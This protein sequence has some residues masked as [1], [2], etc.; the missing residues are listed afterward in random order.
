VNAV[1]SLIACSNFGDCRVAGEA[2]WDERTCACPNCGKML[3]S[4]H[5]VVIR[6]PA[7]SIPE[8]S[9][10]S[11]SIDVEIAK[12]CATFEKLCVEVDGQQRRTWSTAPVP[13]G[14]GRMVFEFND[15]FG[16]GFHT[17]RAELK[18]SDG[19]T[20]SSGERVL[21]V[22]R[23]PRLVAPLIWALLLI[24]LVSLSASLGWFGKPLFGWTP[25]PSLAYLVDGVFWVSALLVG[26][27]LVDLGLRQ[28]AVLAGGKRPGTMP[29][30]STGP[31]WRD[32][33]LDR[34]E[35]P[36]ASSYALIIVGLLPF[37]FALAY[38]LGIHLVGILTGHDWPSWDIT[39][40][41][42]AMLAVAALWWGINLAIK[43]RQLESGLPR[44]T[45]AA[46]SEDAGPTALMTS[47]PEL[48]VLFAAT[49]EPPEEEKSS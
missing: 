46:A 7:A 27:L 38:F 45:A 2:M 31:T 33:V 4:P 3:S 49:G 5:R 13:D 37:C 39:A 26:G 10:F 47:D 34:L 41:I 18:T 14:L 8:N 22:D 43:N 15:D 12:G 42:A 35:G 44:R 9:A 30:R 21:F 25:S 48:G 20:T 24:L 40:L 36:A 6:P 1:S 29:A 17:L 19:R 23:D 28:R 16:G 32:K 11:I